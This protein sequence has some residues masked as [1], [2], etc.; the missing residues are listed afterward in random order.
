MRKCKEM[1]GYDQSLKE[2]YNGCLLI[3]MQ[4]KAIGKKE[5]SGV[6]TCWSEGFKR[7]IEVIPS[8]VLCIKFMRPNKSLGRDREEEKETEERERWRRASARRDGD[9]GSQ[10]G[11]GEEKGSCGTS[12]PAG[13]AQSRWWST[14]RPR[15]VTQ[16]RTSSV[17]EMAA[18]TDERIS[19]GCRVL[20]QQCRGNPAE[21]R[22]Q[23]LRGSDGARAWRRG[24]GRR[25]RRRSSSGAAGGAA[26]PT[27][28]WHVV[29]R[30][31]ARFQRNR[32][33]A[34]EG[35]RSRVSGA[36][37][38]TRARRFEVR[39]FSRAGRQG[40]RPKSDV[41]HGRPS[42]FSGSMDGS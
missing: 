15:E 27:A 23:G 11:N 9:G 7:E 40:P 36:Q 6:L 10:R 39:D 3:F 2:L 19:R 20:Q 4:T 38:E 22:R 31:D 42:I 32:D 26:A 30:S 41:F 34:M 33:D 37:I 24:G 14:R 29:D 35:L 18:S 13:S 28:R 12:A 25:G 5:N 8:T 17:A 1:S 21:R 16:W